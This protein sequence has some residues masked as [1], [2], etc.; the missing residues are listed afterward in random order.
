MHV[1]LRVWVGCVCVCVSLS[2]IISAVNRIFSPGLFFSLIF[3]SNLQ[4]CSVI[5]ALSVDGPAHVCA[6]L[7]IHLE[8][9]S[10]ALF[11]LTQ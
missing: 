9:V 11:P 8:T 6:A 10:T 5:G 2:D 3:L 1:P 7:H 4:L